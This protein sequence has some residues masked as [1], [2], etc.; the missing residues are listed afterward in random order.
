MEMTQL[1]VYDAL[2][3]L[4]P[5]YSGPIQ[6]RVDSMPEL[7]SHMTAQ[8][9]ISN[10]FVSVYSFLKNIPIIDKLFLE[11]DYKDPQTALS[12]GQ[13]L[14]EECTEKYN[15]STIPI[16]SGNRSPHII[17]L[18]KPEILDS[19]SESIKKLAYKISYTSSQYYIDPNTKKYVPYLDT[20]VLEP[21]RLCRFPNTRRVSESGTP[22]QN[23]C[24]ILDPSRFLDMSFEEV[25]ELS[26]SPQTYPIKL[27]PPTQ[28]LSD[29]SIN[30][31]SLD[32]WQG[33]PIS[34]SSLNNPLLESSK[35]LRP[36][37][38]ELMLNALITRPCTRKGMDSPN[39]SHTIRRS[40][41]SE[42]H[43][44]GIEAPFI[45]YLFS[46]LDIFD[47]D[48]LITSYHIQKIISRNFY[49]VSQRDMQ[50]EG[51][52]SIDPSNKECI[53]CQRRR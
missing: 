37:S 38:T 33:A 9:G 25:L 47:Y 48:P 18:F 51:L 13:S 14:F 52:C 19:P 1:Q 7:M 23:H 10:C 26:H 6:T 43:K 12:V 45:E 30:D 16:W 28:K 35:T 3:G 39:P 53:R 24:I 20:R 29:I 15:L 40:F 31:I 4:F 41:V 22:T 5:R 46:I 32:E 27:N 42:L 21:R 11:S 36:S 50:N 8:S 2:F 49:P 34:H 17:P 44:K